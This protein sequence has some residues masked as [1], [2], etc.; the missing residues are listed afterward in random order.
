MSH[1][2]NSIQEKRPISCIKLGR[3]QVLLFDSGCYNFY[4]NS[5]TTKQLIFPA[6]NTSHD[7]RYFFHVFSSARS[8]L[9]CAFKSEFMRMLIFVVE[10]A[11]PL[12]FPAREYNLPFAQIIHS[13][14]RNVFGVLKPTFSSLN[15]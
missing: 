9:A 10:L 11:I 12:F 4:P 15:H 2:H 1:Q 13:Y 6:K 7:E 5:F 8:A 14:V 3:F